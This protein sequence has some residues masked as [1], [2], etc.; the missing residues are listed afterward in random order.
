LEGLSPPEVAR[1]A[2]ELLQSWL[3]VLPR[4]LVFARLVES[5]CHRAERQA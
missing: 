2:E 4:A 3:V 1:R 5:P